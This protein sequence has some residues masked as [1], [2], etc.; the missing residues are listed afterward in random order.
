MRTVKRKVRPLNRGK[1]AQLRGLVDAF[2]V[3]KEHW[4]EV[5]TQRDYRHLIGRS[6]ELRDAALAAKYV[7]QALLQ[8]R[9]WKLALSEAAATWDRYWEAIFADVRSKIHSRND[10]DADD[11]HY[12]FWLL[13][14]YDRFYACLE[15]LAPL[16]KFPI[17]IHRRQKVKF[18]VQRQVRKLRGRNPSV[19]IARSAVFDAN[20]YKVFEE[21]GT[22]YLKLMTQRSRE[23]VVIPLKGKTRISGNIKLILE[24]DGKV[25]I[26]VGYECEVAKVEV[27]KTEAVDMGYTEAFVDTDGAHFGK[28]L[29]LVLSQA[30][31]QRHETGKARN[32]LRA[33]ARRAEESGDIAK[34]RRIR[35]C[36]LG[37]LKW[38]RREAKVKAGLARVINT[39][40]NQIVAAHEPLKVLATEWLRRAFTFN[41]GK[42]ANRRLSN[43]VRGI[44]QER[45][46]FK[47]LVEGFHHEQVNA[48]Y[49]SQAC[50][51]CDFTDSKNRQGDRFV[52]LSCGYED[53]ADRVA[54]NNVER[55]LTDQQITRYTPYREVK[56]ILLARHH[57][58]LEAKGVSAAAEASVV[59]QTLA[60]VP[61]RT[62]DVEINRSGPSVAKR[63]EGGRK[64]A[65]TSKLGRPKK[66]LVPVDPSESET[67][68][69]VR[70]VADNH[71][72]LRF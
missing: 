51:A 72:C 43:W 40:L 17:A 24:A 47:A 69:N 20:C 35:K 57:R 68:Q 19:Q 1:L 39:G 3:E 41:Q 5:L 10:F 16:P 14:D 11:K 58:R 70:N 34:A 66:P 50:P 8:N 61:G 27:G 26:H 45:V 65:I 37:N 38:N 52:C 30:S 63:N 18:Y 4:L 33:I 12:A 6:R 23:R 7:P 54:A 71:V 55:R 15:G 67:K 13:C 29:G 44:L 36:N 28:G 22:Q 2:A 49:S 56:A 48:A 62:P 21:K 32:K 60:T 53:H 9:M 46:E 59:T 64:A 31:L 25:E 42:V